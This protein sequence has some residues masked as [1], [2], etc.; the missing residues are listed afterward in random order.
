MPIL[1]DPTGQ[2]GLVTKTKAP[3]VRRSLHGARV[4]LIDNGKKNADLLLRNMGEILQEQ[5]GVAE[6]ITYRKQS[7]S[8]P[9]DAAAISELGKR[10]DFAIAAIGDS[11]SCSAASVADAIRF[12]EQG[13]PSAAIITEAFRTT[14]DAMA[15]AQGMPDYAYAVIP[16]PVSSLSPEEVRQRA[17]QVVPER[18]QLLGVEDAAE[19]GRHERASDG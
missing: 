13:I 19:Q 1:V 9:V 4:C 12:E 15:Q 17:E 10:C 2:T 16:H 7:I 14:A 5:H 6:L 8:V 18:L 11:G 3:R